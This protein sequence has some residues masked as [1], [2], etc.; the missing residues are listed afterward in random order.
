[1]DHSSSQDWTSLAL[2]V[3]VGLVATLLGLRLWWERADRDRHLPADDRNHFI[4]QDLRRAVGIALMAFVAF[5]VYVG[6][7]LP[8]RIV[9]PVAAQGASAMEAHPNRRFLALWMGVFAAV[10]IL[11]ALAMIDWLSTRRYARRHRREMDRERFEIL[12]ETLHHTG[13]GDDGLGN[14]R[15]KESV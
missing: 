12:R 7:R 1:M 11:L 6:S 15:P 3:A 9:R 2:A 4:L 13:P 8:S 5:G 14:G 10:V